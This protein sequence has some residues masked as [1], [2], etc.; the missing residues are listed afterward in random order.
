LAF[1]ATFT[2]P[3]VEE[4][5]YRGVRYSAFQRTFGVV[6]AVISVTV[7]FAAVHVPQYYPSYVTIALLTFLS[8]ILT[9]V[10]VRTRNLLPCVVLHFMFNAIQSFSLVLEPYL[11]QNPAELPDATTTILRFFI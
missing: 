10:R 11:P 4:V 2:A 1:L 7:L 3:F 6:L 8:L 5:V 9:L